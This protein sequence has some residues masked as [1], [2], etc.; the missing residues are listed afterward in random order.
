MKNIEV[1]WYSG[2]ELHAH[3]RR[4]KVNGI[5]EEVFS[6][7]KEIREDLKNK[8]RVTIFYCHI[9]DNRRIKIEIA[10]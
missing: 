7:E 10:E 1:E 9:G 5:W 2:K 3:P 4:I 8:K 6:F